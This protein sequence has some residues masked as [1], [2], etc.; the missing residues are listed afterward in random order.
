MIVTEIF[1]KIKFWKSADR[2]GADIP[3]THWRLHF[4]STMYNLCKK[5]SSISGK[6]LSLGTELMPLDVLKYPSA[7]GLL[8]DLIV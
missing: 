4:K 2:L 6:V 1:E 3:W 5:K 7:I 8:F